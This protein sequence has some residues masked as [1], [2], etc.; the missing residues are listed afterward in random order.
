[1]ENLEKTLVDLSLAV[2]VILTLLGGW[3]GNLIRL[4]RSVNSKNTGH[5]VLAVVAILTG[6]FCGVLAI[7]DLINLLTHKEIWWLE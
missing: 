3:Y 2:K 7:W 6:G 4:A 5:I 1:M